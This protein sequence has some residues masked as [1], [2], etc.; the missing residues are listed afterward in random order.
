MTDGPFEG[1]PSRSP[2][3]VARRAAPRLTWLALLLV[4]TVQVRKIGWV[5]EVPLVL[6]IVSIPW[7]W[8]WWTHVLTG[9]TPIVEGWL[10]QREKGSWQVLLDAAGA[11]PIQVIKEV[12]EATAWVPQLRPVLVHDL[13]YRCRS[14]A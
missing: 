7:R 5:E 3:A 13:G 12:R 9:R 2:V 4:L 6:L 8:S 14:R 10:A 1:S 11:R